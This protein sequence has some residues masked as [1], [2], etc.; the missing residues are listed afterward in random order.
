MRLTRFAIGAL[1]L[2]T[3]LTASLPGARGQ[4]ATP[5]TAES[6][7]PAWLEFGPEGVLQARA[8]TSSDC[9]PLELDG[10]ETTMLPRGQRDPHFP[11]VACEA[12]I[13]FGVTS[14]RVRDTPLPLPTGPLRR[15]AVVGDTGCRLNQWEKA[16]QNCNDPVAWP[17]A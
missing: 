16:Y 15:I 3:T 5:A 7:L 17:F 1:L 2:V 12:I 8:L 13:P 9:P 11:V 14:A 10:R 4:V 6:F